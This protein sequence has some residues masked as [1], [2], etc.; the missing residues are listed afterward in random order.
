[1]AKRRS[2]ESVLAAYTLAKQIYA[3]LGVD[4]DV[5]LQILADIPVSIH[6]WQGDDVRGFE[7]GN[8]ELTGGIQATGNY[9]GRAT[10]AAE[11]RQDLDEAFR[12]IPGK[13]RL[14]LHAI[15]LEQEGEKVERDEIA[16]R[17][18]AN[19]VAWA[20]E[21]DIGL[22]FNPTL[23]SHEKSGDGLTLSHPDPEIRGFWIRH[24]KQCRKISEYFGRELG[25]PSV[26]NIWI[27]DGFKDIP[28]DRLAP[29]QRLKE[30]LDEILM[31]KLDSRCHL[32]AIESKLF[33]IGSE[34][35][36]VG[37]HE[38]YMGYAIQNQTVLCLDAGHFHPT[39]VISNKISAISLFVEK[40]LLHVSRPVRWDSDHVVTLDDELL[41]I[42]QEIIRHN[43][44]DRVMIGL[45]FF[46]ASINREAAWIIGTRNMLKALAI[47]LLEPTWILKQAEL[48]FDL[49]ARL[50]MLEESKALPW[51]AVWDYFC[52][53]QGVPVGMDWLDDIRTYERDVLARRA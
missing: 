45:D 10:T 52:L 28:A 1:M 31:E 53:K 33:G 17:H 21:Q 32:D 37:S 36:V 40:M 24:V 46:D 49:T 43:L 20:K 27:P 51:Q 13:K 42:A 18:F 14:N 4:T 26:M 5:A 3:D 9:M 29:R 23:F 19:W 15:Y 22:D 39:E 35:Y 34:S 50:A 6:C 7:A 11:L 47:A 25:T 12:L 16:P 2:E 8:D 41:S 48:C 38:F 44:L 30:S